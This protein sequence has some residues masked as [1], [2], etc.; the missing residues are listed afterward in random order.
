MRSQFRILAHASRAVAV[1]CLFVALGALL[2]PAPAAA[3]A[4]GRAVAIVVHPQTVADNLTFA[5]LRSIF[6]G[7]QQ[8]WA[9]R[10][11]ITLLVRAPVAAEREFVLNRIYRMNEAQFRQYWIA[12]MFR[13]E[14][15]SGPKI[16]VSSDMTRE[17]V[18]AIPGAIGFMPAADVGR[19]VK[20]LRIDGKLP[21]DSGY[22]LR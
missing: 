8:F 19:D 15:A 7:E 3:Q 13:A 18:S 5:Q 6:L 11:R 12:K 10:S 14:V 21:G 20:V 17:L 2:S 4:D 9:D 16:V 1:F 22:L